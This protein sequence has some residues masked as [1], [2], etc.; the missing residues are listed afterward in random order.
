[1][2]TSL[3][4]RRALFWDIPESN[5]EQALAESDE[6][7]INRVFENGTLDDIFEAIDLYGEPRVKAVL[8]QSKM[9]RVTRAMARLLFDLEQS[10]V[11]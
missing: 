10:D 11:A 9:G 2:E 1:M 8:S 3:K 5:I 4:Y 6:W 7:V